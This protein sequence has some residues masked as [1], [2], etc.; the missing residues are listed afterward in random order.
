MYKIANI[1]NLKFIRQYVR[2]LEI[3]IKEIEE[4]N[5]YSNF[6]REVKSANL[7]SIDI[8]E[9]LTADYISHVPIHQ[10][11]EKHVLDLNPNG[12][13]ELPLSVK[14]AFDQMM[15]DVGKEIVGYS[16][17]D[18]GRIS[19]NNKNFAECVMQLFSLVVN[20]NDPES[21]LVYN[22]EKGY[23][24]DATQPLHRLIIE[25]AHAA[26]ENI[27]DSWTVHIEKSIVEILKRKV[28][29]IESPN[30]NKD[31]FP[32]GNY[33]LNSTTGELVP[34]AS[35]HLATFGSSVDCQPNTDCSVFQQFLTTLFHDVKTIEF[36]QEW[37]GYTLSTSHKANAFLIGVGSGANGKSTLFD[38][39]VR[40]VGIENV[41]SAPLSNFN[42]DFGLEPLVGKKLNLAT[43]SD[44]D[45]FKTGKLK[46]L[47]AGEDIS[48]NRKNKMEIT[49]KLPAKLV[50]L[51]NELPL[52]T[53][54]SF[55]FE[56][57]LL[58][59]P[60]DKTFLPHEQDKDLPKKLNAELEGI[61]SWA[62]EGL[63]RLIE[64]NYNFTVSSTMQ[65]AKDKYFGVGNPVE[66]FVEECVIAEPSNVMDAR[67]LLNAYSIWMTN[68]DFPFKG[69][70]T[71]Q[72]F[73][74]SFKEVMD[75]K[76]IE[77]TRGKSNGKTVVRDIALK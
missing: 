27:E 65:N 33:T 38:V 41:A 2:D 14:F 12:N 5:S 52:L 64:N 23:W 54:D 36:V 11:I 17:S 13:S 50:F 57:R 8:L 10:L 3:E 16:M 44:V 66:K 28:V 63:K 9:K 49:T 7:K 15:L 68:N 24:E 75:V 73:W 70:D 32:L 46:A 1:K 74:K 53:D 61:L 20:R 56:R 62:L 25:I 51:V 48:I 58:I 76:L 4:F 30:F 77:F 34:H 60:F 29:F 47:T 18:S 43:E 45:A 39:L 31:H 69:T 6:V 59:L 42:S 40:L 72:K 22:K 67:D 21:L 55:G 26:G 19:F 37:F 35:S 71:P